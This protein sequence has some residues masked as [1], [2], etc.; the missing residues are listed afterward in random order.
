MMTH[1]ALLLFTGKCL[2]MDENPSVRE[3]VV[4]A[5][6]AGKV[7]WE[8][9]VWTGSSHYVLPALYTAFERNGILPL[10]PDDL[11]EHLR[12]IYTLNAAR[13]KRIIQQCLQ[14]SRLLSAANIRP[15]FFKGAA[16]LLMGLF[17]GDGDRLMEDIDILLPEAEI[18]AALD[19]LLKGGYVPHPVEEGKDGTYTDHHHLPPMYHPGEVATLEIHRSPVHEGYDSLIT[20]GE[21]T[22]EA[23]PAGSLLVAAPRHARLLVFL[24]EH[25]MSRGSLAS[26]GTLKGAFDFYLLTRL[27]SA[28]YSEIPKG[29]WRKKFLRY[30]RTVERVTGTTL[31][32]KWHE[33]KESGLLKLGW[34]KELFLLDHPGIDYFYHEYLYAPAVFLKLLVKSTGSPADRKL[35]AAKLRKKSGLK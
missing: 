11:T 15:V 20:A 27:Y 8:E 21:V 31:S 1:S 22:R 34:R 9:F 10:L 17:P 19:I 25:R 13:N 29:K 18:P 16:L 33:V 7:P 28:Q 12:N 35:V 5:I 2:A 30:T 23:V 6:S 32:G 4:A 26:S 3:E 14:I 24:H